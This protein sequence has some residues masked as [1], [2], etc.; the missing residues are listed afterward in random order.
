MVTRTLNRTKE[1]CLQD[2]RCCPLP[3]ELTAPGQSGI[4]YT[5]EIYA[6]VPDLQGAQA[7]HAAVAQTADATAGVTFEANQGQ[8]DE[9]VDFLSQGHGYTIFLTAKE[10]VL[11]LAGATDLG[12][13]SPTSSVVRMRWVDAQPDPLVVGLGEQPGASHYLVGNDPAEWKTEI[14]RYASVRYHEIYSGI[15]LVYYGNQG[16]LE[17]DWIVEPGSDPRSDRCGFQRCRRI[18]AGR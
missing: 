3:V 6:G 1:S 15:D 9:Q 17:Y 8:T 2:S 18:G 5:P 13:E 10:A 11:R 4:I 16:E 14:R 7:A 12:S